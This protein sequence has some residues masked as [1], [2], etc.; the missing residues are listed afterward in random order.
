MRAAEAFDWSIELVETD[1][2]EIEAVLHL[3]VCAVEQERAGG[4][5]EEDV[6]RSGEDG[7]GGRD[8]EGEGSGGDPAGVL[9]G[10][11]NGAGYLRKTGG[12]IG[13]EAGGV[14]GGCREGDRLQE[15]TVPGGCGVWLDLGAF[16]EEKLAVPVPAMVVM[17]PDWE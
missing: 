16:D 9:D 11:G 10:D 4:G 2:E 3:E 14:R 7:A 1:R 5:G 8:V 17:M 15:K 6:G 13:Q 12:D